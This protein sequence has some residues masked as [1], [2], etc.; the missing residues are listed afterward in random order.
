MKK[1]ATGILVAAFFFLVTS[2]RFSFHD[3]SLTLGAFT[4]LVALT[5]LSSQWVNMVVVNVVECLDRFSVGSYLFVES[6]VEITGEHTHYTVK[7]C[8]G[9][10]RK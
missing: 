2:H 3:F 4:C 6:V 5:N 8:T 10:L 7:I 9:L 1:A